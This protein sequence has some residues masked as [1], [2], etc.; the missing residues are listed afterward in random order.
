MPRA[1]ALALLILPLLGSCPTIGLRTT[2]SLEMGFNTGATMTPVA[3]SDTPLFRA[4]AVFDSIAGKAG[5]HAP[6]ITAFPDGELL[7]AWYSYNGPHELDGAAIYTARRLPGSE[8]W[9]PPTLH[10]DRPAADGNPVLYSE[11]DSVWL[12]QAVVSG[13]GWSTAHIEVQRSSNRGATWLSPE[14]I[15]G[16]LGANVRF[17]P[18]RTRDSEL[19]LPAYN[20][21]VLQ[22]LFFVSPNGQDWT[23]RAT[24]ATAP[25]HECLQP[26]VVTLSDGRLLAVLRNRGQ[27]WLWV[28]S[29]ADDGRTW[30]TPADSGFPNPGSA[31]A[32]LRL[33][34]GHLVLVYNDSPS[35]RR[36]LSTTVSADDGATWYPPRLLVD[37]PGSY[38]Y[39][40]AIQT[41]DGLIHIVYSDDR[42]RIGHIALNEAWIVAEAP[43]SGS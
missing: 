37:G 40:A 26:S 34:N 7:A 39:P 32:L 15:V 36:P 31:A 5:S 25:P 11:G 3:T 22:A 30:A 14:L 28:T 38:A 13:T 16:P 12:F 41:P 6:T 27:E 21:L 35:A 24:V 42:Q 8:T 2:N 33:A 19:L 1:L 9:E 20:D 29:S 43:G 17:P 10:I 23:L 18:I 4:T